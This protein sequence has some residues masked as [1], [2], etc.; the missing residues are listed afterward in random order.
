MFNLKQSNKVIHKFQFYV[1]FFSFNRYNEHKNL[2]EILTKESDDLKS[3]NN[4][5]LFD[6]ENMRIEAD[7]PIREYNHLK[8]EFDGLT[9]KF[10]ELQARYLSNLMYEIAKG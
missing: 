9:A 7:K 10:N 2:N 3:L 5:L 6:I 1:Y 4:K 8:K